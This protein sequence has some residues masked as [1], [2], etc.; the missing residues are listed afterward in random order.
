MKVI[1]K[2]VMDRKQGCGFKVSQHATDTFELSA[3]PT[4]HKTQC[5]LRAMT[6]PAPPPILDDVMR[7]V[8]GAVEKR[9][10]WRD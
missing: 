3:H 6:F 4:E 5:L 9:E 1:A 2:T 10:Q 7:V 8:L